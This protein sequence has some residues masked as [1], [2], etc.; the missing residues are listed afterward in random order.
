[1]KQHLSDHF[2]YKKLIRYA[3]P[4]VVMTMFVSLYGIMDGIF[5]SNFADK[6]SFAAISFIL[7]FVSAINAFGYM[8]GTGGA[9]LIAKTLGEHE[10]EKANQLF[11][12]LIIFTVIIGIVMSAVGLLIMR[13]VAIM[14]GASGDLLEKSVL[15]GGIMISCQTEIMLQTVFQS[16][17]P[18]AEKPKM[19][20]VLTITAGGVDMLFKSCLLSFFVGGSSVRRFLR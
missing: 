4:S 17:L 11:S 16:L 10:R 1:M 13:P 7:P 14:M 8:I 9:A 20:L 12:L 5:V 18:A 6:T 15:Y 2:T 19:G 3:L